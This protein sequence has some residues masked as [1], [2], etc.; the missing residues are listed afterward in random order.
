M[1]V[2][3]LGLIVFFSVHSVRMVAGGFRERQLEASPGRWK[4]IYS[5][6][7]LVGFG[8]IVWGWILFRAEAPE[9]YEPPAWGR[10]VAMALVWIAFILLAAN[11]R[12]GRINAYLKHPFL[13]GVI[14]WSAAHLLANGDLASVLLFGTFLVYAVVNRIAVIPRGDPAPAVVRPGSDLIAVLAGT[15]LYVV[16]VLWLHGWLFG[17]PLLG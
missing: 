1:W 7:S 17:V 2:L 13:T 8:L 5:L 3:I 6:I 15:A 9:I 11:M 14:L 16:F 10:H 12:A 4:G